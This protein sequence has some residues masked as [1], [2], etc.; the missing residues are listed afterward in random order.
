[1]NKLEVKEILDSLK[2]E[3][4]ENLEEIEYLIKKLDEKSE[5]EV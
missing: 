4:P 1:M 2:H 3:N 5:E